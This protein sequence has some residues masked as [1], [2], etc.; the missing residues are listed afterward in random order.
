MCELPSRSANAANWSFCSCVLERQALVDRARLEPEQ[1]E[2]VD[3]LDL[4]GRALGRAEDAA[5]GGST[6]LL[7]LVRQLLRLEPAELLHV[8]VPPLLV[9]E[10]RARPR[11]VLQLG[12]PQP[13]LQRAREGELQR[14]AELMPRAPHL[15]ADAQPDERAEDGPGAVHE[16]LRGH[17]D[18]RE[19]QP[20][21]GDTHVHAD[22]RHV[23]EHHDAVKRAH[24]ARSEFAPKQV[25]AR[26]EWHVEV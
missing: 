17:V 15:P 2:D 5:A 8:H 6:T 22:D 7:L 25:E 3:R 4:G 13:R 11:E 9:R 18:R 1:Q 26:A 10:V 23:G 21:R 20:R 12:A 14:L 19:Q 16:V 24:R